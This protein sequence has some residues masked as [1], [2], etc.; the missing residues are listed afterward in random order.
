MRFQI[1]GFGVRRGTFSQRHAVLVDQENE[2]TYKKFTKNMGK[3]FKEHGAKRVVDCWGASVPDGD[4]TSFPLAV[5]AE[6]GEVV[7][8]GWIEW[9]SQA[10]RDEGMEKAMSDE[11]GKNLIALGN[12]TTAPCRKSKSIKRSLSNMFSTGPSG[13]RRYMRMVLDF[14]LV[15]MPHTPR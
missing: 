14:V 10:D 2:E 3:I 11:P 7:C 1:G 13:S 5:K 6:E 15:L 9:E 8:I 4:V 12:Q